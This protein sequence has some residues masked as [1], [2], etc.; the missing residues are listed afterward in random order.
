[1]EKPRF[2]SVVGVLFLVAACGSSGSGGGA[3]TTACTLQSG[4]SRQCVET[5]TNAAVAGGIAAAQSDCVKG[6]GVAS[7]T[8]SH[9]GA[10][11][12]CKTTFSSGALMVSTT[13]W[14]YAGAASSEMSGCTASGNAWIA[15]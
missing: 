10:D 8:C 12:G 14:Y 7:D 1:M 2:Q 3:G 4:T 15:P 11:G 13:I 5:S 6:G 9:T